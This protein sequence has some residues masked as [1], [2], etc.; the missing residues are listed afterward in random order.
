M[1]VFDRF[2]VLERAYERQERLVT[3]TLPHLAYHRVRLREA[4]VVFVFLMQHEFS[5]HRYVLPLLSQDVGRLLQSNLLLVGLE[6]TLELFLFDVVE[7]DLV[8]DLLV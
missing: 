5:Q 4:I 8:D 6:G 3:G 7:L 1:F 2:V